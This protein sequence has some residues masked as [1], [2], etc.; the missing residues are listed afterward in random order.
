MRNV[1]SFK[2]HYSDVFKRTPNKFLIYPRSFNEI[3]AYSFD[4][5]RS[6]LFLQNKDFVKLSDK[7]KV[8]SNLLV[9]IYKLQNKCSSTEEFIRYSTIFSFLINEIVIELRKQWPNSIYYVKELFAEE[10]QI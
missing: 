6:W 2:N 4:N 7:L 1:F 3:I 8:Q 10:Y 9:E 5:D